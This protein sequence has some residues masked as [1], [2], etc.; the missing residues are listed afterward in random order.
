M[1]DVGFVF[2]HDLITHFFFGGQIF[3]RNRGAK[4]H[5]ALGMNIGRV[6]DVRPRKFV[7]HVGNAP[8]DKALA[9]FGRFVFGI[10]R[11]I[12]MRTRFGY[13]FNHFG[14]RYAFQV[15]QFCFQKLRAA[16]G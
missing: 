15:L 8:F 10:F 16:Y 11:Q 3:Q 13:R 1:L 12:A 2:A 5:F 4:H 9:L 14:T 6:D 7:F